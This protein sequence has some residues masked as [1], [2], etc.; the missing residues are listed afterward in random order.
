MGECMNISEEVRGAL[1][2]DIGSGDITAALV[3]AEQ[4]LEAEIITRE[5]MLVCGQ[6]WVDTVFSE[7]DP[8]VQCQWL[9]PEGAWLANPTGLCRINGPARAILT[10]ER[11]ALNFLQTLSGTATQTHAFLQALTGTSTRLLDTRKT[12]PGLRAAQKYAVRCAGAMNHRMG[13]YDAFLIKENHIAAY[14]S[15]S[16]AISMARQ[17]HPKKFLE[18]EVQNLNELREA[19]ACTPDRILLDNFDLSTISA[20]VA[21][22]QP[23]ICDLEVS[24]GVDV[25]TIRSLAETGVDYISVGALTK[26]VRAIDLSLLVKNF[27]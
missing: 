19:L 3:P 1:A 12:M 18:V 11:T 10:G 25:T 27:S 2:E 26:S 22:N 17:A 15:I 13:L 4:M 8:R 24:G 5:P 7:L 6:A 21:L 14:G 20:A 9:V 23:K 16:A